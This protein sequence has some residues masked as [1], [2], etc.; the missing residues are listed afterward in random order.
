MTG[1]LENLRCHVAGRAARGRQHVELF[2]IHDPTQAKIGNQ[3]ICIIL[4]RAEE[5]V[6]GLQVT[7]DNA[8][9]MQVCD[10]RKSG[11][12]EVG[13]I[14]LVVAAFTANAVEKLST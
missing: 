8:M 12:D 13:G 5:Q 9:V 3:K 1:L 6:L 14:G 10:S 11:A 7:M 2:L 4:R